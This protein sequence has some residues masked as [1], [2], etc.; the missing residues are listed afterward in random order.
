[1]RRAWAEDE[2]EMKMR[3]MKSIAAVI[4]LSAFSTMSLFSTRSAIP[5]SIAFHSG[6]PGYIRSDSPSFALPI[7]G[8]IPIQLAAVSDPN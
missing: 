3:A 6:V 8:L 1:M 2:G 7:R 5:F 4:A